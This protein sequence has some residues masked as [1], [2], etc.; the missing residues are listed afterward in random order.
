[1]AFRFHGLGGYSCCHAKK[2]GLW[3]DPRY[4][5]R[6]EMEL[7]GSGIELYKFGLLDVPSYM[8]W[9]DQ[10]L[11]KD[12]VIGFDGNVISR[13]EQVRL[14]NFFQ[15]KN[16]TFVTQRDLVGELWQGRPGVPKIRYLY[17]M[18]SSLAN[19]GNQKLPEFVR[20]SKNVRRMHIC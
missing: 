8:E 7:A 16:I 2:A 19:H 10:E 11:D 20:S 13:A 17:M 5:I 12:S 3:T 1:M 15:G 14:K 18:K 6:G 4:H 9:L